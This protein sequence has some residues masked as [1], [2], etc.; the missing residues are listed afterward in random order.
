MESC[1]PVVVTARAPAAQAI[2]TASGRAMP[3]AMQT[4]SRAVEGVSGGHGI[5]RLDP[6]CGLEA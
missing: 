2:R 3:S 5:N 1:A 6:E 4:A